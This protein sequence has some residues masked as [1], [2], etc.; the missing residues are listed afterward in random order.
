MLKEK[1]VFISYSTRDI[2]VVNIVLRVLDEM[3]VKY[4]KAPEMIPAGSSYAQEIVSAISNCG[5]V[6]V[7]MSANSQSSQWVEKE[8]DSA[9]NY[10][11]KIIPLMIDDTPMNSVFRF[12]LNNV[13]MIYYPGD[14]KAAIEELKQHVAHLSTETMTLSDKKS[15]FLRSSKPSAGDPAGKTQ[16]SRTVKK[17]AAARKAPAASAAARPQFGTQGVKA[18]RKPQAPRMKPVSFDSL[19][20]RPVDCEHCGGALEEIGNGTYRCLACGLES[21]DDFQRIRNYITR[22]GPAPVTILSRELGIPRQIVNDFR[23]RNGMIH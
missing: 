13:Q 18:A 11:R 4:W 7:F 21:Y 20:R 19:N 10:N 23:D 2:A 6:L 22:N 3:N 9:V 8:I 15:Q 5:L 14:P 17:G 1:Y 12:Y 16:V